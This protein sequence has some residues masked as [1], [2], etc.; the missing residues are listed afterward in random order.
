M[1]TL[2]NLT[3]HSITLRPPSG[4]DIVLPPDPRGPARLVSSKCRC[5][6]R[7]W[8]GFPVPLQEQAPVPTSVVGLPGQKAGVFYIVALLVLSSPLL[9]GRGDVLAPG[10]GPDEGVIREGGQVKAVTRLIA[11]IRGV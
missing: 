7:D 8:A 3:P 5:P 10:T 11:R 1:V 2:V 4:P 6:P 9:A